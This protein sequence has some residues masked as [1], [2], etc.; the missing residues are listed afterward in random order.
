MYKTIQTGPKS[1]LG[2]VKKGF[3]RAGYQSSIPAWVATPPKK[4]KKRQITTA[5]ELRKRSF[6]LIFLLIELLK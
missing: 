5:M 2:G 1:Q 3:S 6:L 4:P